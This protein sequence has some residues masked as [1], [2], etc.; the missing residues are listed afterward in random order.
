M[1]GVEID[2]CKRRRCVK[3]CAVGESAQS[4]KCVG[5]LTRE[6]A[7]ETCE[8]LWEVCGARAGREVV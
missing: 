6:R 8:S 7:E 1:K 3:A 4:G 5:S 2:L